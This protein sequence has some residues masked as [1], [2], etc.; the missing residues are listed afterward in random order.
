MRKRAAQ[1]AAVAGG[2]EP[3][4][5][6]YDSKRDFGATPEPSSCARA[7]SR[8]AADPIFVV[9]KHAA[10]SLHYDFRLEAE[11]VLWSWAVPKGPSTDPA[12]KR[13][14]VRTEDHPVAYAS[15]AGRIPAGQYGA[16]VV[17]IWDCGTWQP[18]GD[19]VQGLRD[20][21]LAFQLHGSQLQGNWELVRMKP[22]DGERQ[23]A[24]LLFKKKDLVI[25][26]PVIEP[27]V[28]KLPVIKL[29]VIT[30]AEAF[31]PLQ[32]QLA[33]L[34]AVDPQTLGALDRRTWL[35][36]DKFDGYRILAHLQGGRARLFTRNGHDWTAK[37]RTLAQAIESLPAGSAWF[38]GE[39]V[40]RSAAGRADFNQLQ[41]AFDGRAKATSLEYWLFDLPHFDGHDLRA[42]ALEQRRALLQKLLA[43][44]QPL[45]PLRFSD[46][47][48]GSAGQAYARAC[49]AGDEGLIAKRRDATYTGGRS[50]AWLKLKCRRRQEF[51]IG[52]YTLRQGFGT[53]AGTNAGT[54]VSTNV[55]T[56][57]GTRAE[58]EVGSL[59]LGVFDDQGALQHAGSVGTGWSRAMAHSLHQVLVK[60]E[61]ASSPFSTPSTTAT[62]MKSAAR[63]APAPSRWPRRS[64]GLEHWVRPAIV[65]EVSF[66]EWT[67]AG[68]VRHASFVALRQDK[69]AA[70]VRREQE[71]VATANAQDA[72]VSTAKR[73]APAGPMAGPSGS[74][75]AAPTAGATASQRGSVAITH[76][77]REIDRNSGTTKAQ[78]VAYFDAVADWLLPEL[79]GRPVALV[80]APQGVDGTQFF[81][82]HLQTLRLPGVKEL[83][84]ALWPGH[85]PLLQ[86]DTRQ[87]LL[88]AAQ[89]NVIELHTGN[90]RSATLQTPE[91]VVLDLDPG[92]GVAWDAVCEG[93]LLVKALLG[94]LGLKCALKTSGGKGLHEV[95]PIAPR[96]SHDEVKAFAKALVQHLA[97]TVPARFVSRS[98]PNHRVGRIFV[99]YL[100]NAFS[101]T[102]VAAFSP[103][104][105]P[106]LGVSM[107]L[108]W[109]DLPQLKSSAQWTVATAAAHLSAR[110]DDPWAWL[111]RSRQSLTHP[112]AL[113][114]SAR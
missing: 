90:A 36:E 99:D 111:R 77:Q 79:K 27:P 40:A 102:T 68:H 100:R 114:R 76:G 93:A 2:T 71:A 37:L 30:P 11:G 26:S 3:A 22:R 92:E 39:V 112:F 70:Q 84:A 109:A 32:P 60:I 75:T 42:Q 8:A 57:V 98:G 34:S 58:A 43:H 20:G 54:N 73:A 103:R 106:G 21:K 24:W 48:A 67:P 72:T 113:L 50:A 95:V 56:K 52:G 45:S 91:R 74:P 18:Q 104:A 61:R 44:G 38:D 4:L 53:N 82:K 13:M 25:K 63:I 59:L 97:R 86:I 16:G 35:F 46:E 33:T 110:G 94:E 6:L 101:A 69:P 7:G 23:A 10:R 1:A 28:I 85:A 9:Q 105:R 65:A 83:A 29:P 55:G 87:G 5:A 81:Q 12:D 62:S 19:P 107:T 41:K 89:M 31:Q 108:D 88:A 78:L 17:E 47:L 49:R 15:F 14:A 64:H 80:R 96:G 66:A 51:V